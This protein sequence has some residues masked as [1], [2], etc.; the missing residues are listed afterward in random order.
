MHWISRMIQL[1]QIPFRFE[2]FESFEPFPDM[3]VDAK[4]VLDFVSRR[5]H[6][7]PGP[8]TYLTYLGPAS[9]SLESPR[10]PGFLGRGEALWTL[11]TLWTLSGQADAAR[12][13]TL[14]YRL[15]T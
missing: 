13:T 9:L 14:G 7:R 6:G 2:S 12:C 5:Q 11:W 1:M 4:S 8:W 10:L 3:L 15:E